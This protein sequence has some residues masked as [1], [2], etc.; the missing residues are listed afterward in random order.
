MTATYV[1]RSSADVIAAVPFVLGFH[2]AHS[3]VAVGLHAQR[4]LFAARYDLPAAAM[5]EEQ[6]R[7]LAAVTKGQGVNGIILI[8]YG[9][10]EQ[11]TPAVR[12]AADEIRRSG[13]TVLDEMRVTEGQ[14]W[15]YL[16]A[17]D[18]CCPKPC[19]P[20]DSEVAAEAT[21]AGQ[22]ALPDR[23]ALVA[24]RAP[25]TGPDREAMRAA[26]VRAQRRLTDEF[27]AE[28]H[29]EDFSRA[30]RRTG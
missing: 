21:F 5:V 20:P 24:Q 30:L 27:A 8:G 3:L 25:V 14:F 9:P 7:H 28:Q 29:D 1:L 15:S 18:D 19:P 6:A 2:P 26:T 10:E 17:E 22:V 11:V 16:C 4:V 13:M 23:A 12:H